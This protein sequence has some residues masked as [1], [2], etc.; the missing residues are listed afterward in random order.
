MNNK[1]KETD[2]SREEK[3]IMIAKIIIDSLI[4]CFF[5]ILPP[6]IIYL[7]INGD[8]SLPYYLANLIKNIDLESIYIFAVIASIA[9]FFWNIYTKGSVKYFNDAILTLST[10]FTAFKV[11]NMYDG[12]TLPFIKE[13]VENL[14]ITVSTSY[15]FIVCGFAKILICILDFLTS[16]AKFY[17]EKL[18]AG[19]K[20]PT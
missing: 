14:F 12:T 20:K 13:T 10:I 4:V 17:K 8:I 2:K 11:F 5:F 1:T 6:M 16:R 3:S 19:N 7:I 15:L 18:E 9:I